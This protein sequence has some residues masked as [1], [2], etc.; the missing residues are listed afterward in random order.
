MK[1][2]L[3]KQTYL[4]VF[5]QRPLEPTFETV[6]IESE[7]ALKAIPITCVSILKGIT[8]ELSVYSGEE[9]VAQEERPESIKSVHFLRLTR[10]SAIA[11][12][13]TSGTITLVVT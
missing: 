8:T 11:V 6:G 9:V 13:Q 5:V 7:Q 4:K 2:L 10:T 1:I 3:L 12:C